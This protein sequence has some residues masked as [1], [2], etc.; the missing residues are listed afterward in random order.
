MRPA[1][2]KLGGST[3]SAAGM[4]TWVSALAGSVLPLVIVPGGGPF[5]DQVRQSQTRLGFSDGAAHAMAILAMDQFGHV[6]L[7]RDERL[8]PT[9]SF[10]DMRRVM[11]EGRIPVWLPSSATISA[12]DIPATWDITSELACRLARRSDRSECAVADQ[13][14]FGVFRRR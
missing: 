9:R 10:D 11:G 3:A 5:A 12:S 8:I 13:A 2:V 1:V 4:D 6:I 7:D 14:D